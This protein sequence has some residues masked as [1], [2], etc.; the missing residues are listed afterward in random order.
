MLESVQGS[1]QYQAIRV[2]V[3]L[4]ETTGAFDGV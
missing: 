1:N 2:K 4:R 3:L